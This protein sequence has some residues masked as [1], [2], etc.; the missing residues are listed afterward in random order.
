MPF[1]FALQEIVEHRLRVVQP[2]RHDRHALRSPR[3]Q[4]PV[5]RQALHG[6]GTGQ[7]D[8]ALV[9]VGLIVQSLGIGVLADRGVDLFARH[10]L[11]DVGIVG[12]A[13]ERDV[14]D[15][16]ID[17]SLTNVGRERGLLASARR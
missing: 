14:R 1:T 6:E 5:G 3:G 17:E 8:S 9:L 15:R 10:P 7:A 16:A 2:Y 4:H 12:D 11:G 13:L